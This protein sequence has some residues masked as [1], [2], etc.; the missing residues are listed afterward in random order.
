MIL[1]LHFDEFTAKLKLKPAL[2]TYA[3][4]YFFGENIELL[5]FDPYDPG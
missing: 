5:E 4:M 1:K 2:V 3:T